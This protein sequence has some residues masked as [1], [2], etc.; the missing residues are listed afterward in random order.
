MSCL[1]QLKF[2]QEVTENK[3]GVIWVE[4][5]A[6]L[7]IGSGSS[8][9]PLPGGE[10]NADASVGFVRLLV[11]ATAVKVKTPSPYPLPRGEGNADASVRFHASR[12][13]AGQVAE[14][15]DLLDYPTASGGAPAKRGAYEALRVKIDRSKRDARCG[16]LW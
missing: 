9:Y 3:G 4:V 15:A 6:S 13:S 11:A 12:Y 16:Q 10:G 8:T 7:P 5:W 1:S 14:N 2:M